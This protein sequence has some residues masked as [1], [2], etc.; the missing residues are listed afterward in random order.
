MLRELRIENLILV[1]RAKIGFEKGFNVL[2]GETGSGKSAIMG[3]LRLIMGERADPQWIRRGASKGFVEA[4]FD[5]DSLSPVVALLDEAGI[6]WDEAGLVIRR[7]IGG[8]SRAFV[9]NQVA[10]LHLLKRLQ[11]HLLHLVD[12]HANHALVSRDSHR[13]LLDLFGG[14]V[15]LLAAFRSAWQCERELEE[16]LQS[17]KGRE[18]ERLREMEVCRMEVAELEEA[19]LQEGEEEE[20]FHEFSRLSNAETLSALSK[21]LIGIVAD[22]CLAQLHQGR[23]AVAKLVELDPSQE[24][25]RKTVE[26]LSVELEEVAYTLRAYHSAT[27]PNPLR[28]AQLDER[29]SLINRM[30]RK[31]GENIE[32]IHAYL[33]RRQERL[34]ELHN[35]DDRIESLGKLLKERRLA[36]EEAA[37]KLTACRQAAAKEL[38][39][40]LTEQIRPLNMPQAEVR[41]AIQPTP[42]SSNGHDLVTFELAPNV[43][44]RFVAL[45]QGVSGGEMARLMLA[46]KTVLA[47]KEQVGTL[48]FDELDANIGGETAA[49]VGEKLG[50]IAEKHQLLCIT[51]FAQV[52]APAR[53]HL[54]ICKEEKEGRT[55]T[56]VVPLVTKERQLELAR[57]VGGV[58][59][60][61]AS[62]LFAE[63]VVTECA[64]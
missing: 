64:T 27:D 25:M 46:I 15:P 22:G 35:A 33:A 49:V 26:S 40:L 59:F 41:C 45:G 21:Q 54:Q 37:Q 5:I 19:A 32:D 18:A 43:G 53:H 14:S 31:Y 44:E 13:S 36:T 20:L 17:L 10:T 11:P 61:S 34:E 51:H 38:Q 3:A 42:R 23:G 8:R 30:K 12:Q 1:E 52:A 6:A 9:N 4:L 7:E 28:L 39:E 24:E 56:K 58:S 63:K 29:L 62:R 16:E 50:T 48:V 57:M 55:L 60:C 47:G 2:T